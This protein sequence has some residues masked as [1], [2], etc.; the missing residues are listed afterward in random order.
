MGHPQKGAIQTK[1]KTMTRKIKAIGLGLLLAILATTA[2]VATGASAGEEGKPGTL[3]AAEYPATLDGTD[4]TGTNAFTLFGEKIVCP[5]SS[6]TGQITKATT[7]FTITPTYN[8]ANCSA[9]GGGHKVTIT[10]NGCDYLFHIN[11]T[12]EAFVDNY[13]I[14][15][16]LLC[17]AGKDVEIHKYLNVKD[18]TTQICKYTIKEQKGIS[19]GKIAN[20]VDGAGKTTGTLTLENTFKKIIATKTGTCGEGVTEL[21]EYDVHITFKGTNS[22]AAANAIDIT[23]P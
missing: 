13:F 17:P 9:G 10:M 11:G 7:T 22:K 16:D 12:T 4:D 19:G 20:E 6:Y 14:S 23:D 5:D 8:N 18:E 3:T 2:L 15:V 21:G 1:G